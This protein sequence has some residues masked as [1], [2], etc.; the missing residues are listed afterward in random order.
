MF[1]YSMQQQ[2]NISQADC[3]MQQK[4]DF[5]RQPETT[6]SVVGL[7]RSSKALPKATFDQEKVMVT[8]WWSAAR[9]IHYNFLNCSETIIPEKYAQQIKKTHWKLQH[10]QPT[11]A[12]R[13]GP[14]LS[15]DNV[16]QHVTQPTSAPGCEVLPRPLCSP[17]PSRPSATSSPTIATTV[18]RENASTSS[19]SRKC[20]P[21]SHWIPKHG[22]FLLGLDTYSFLAK[23][24]LIVMVPILINRDVF[25]PSYNDLKFRIQ[26][27]YY[28]CTNLILNAKRL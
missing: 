23:N 17:D 14:V 25:E 16:R 13:E 28:F 18:C 3:D 2:Q 1:S 20:F 12:T 5:I 22:Y 10:L 26:N 8:V 24:V 11:L 4:V 6:S 19:R 9:L 15:H 7:R 21:G 27:C